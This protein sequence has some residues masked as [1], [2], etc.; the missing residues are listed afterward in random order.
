MHPIGSAL[1]K[2]HRRLMVDIP[3]QGSPVA[4]GLNLEKAA[5]RPEIGIDAPKIVLERFRILQRL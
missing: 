2:L 4:R 1:R 5:R 3:G